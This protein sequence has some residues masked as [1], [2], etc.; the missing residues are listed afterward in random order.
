M[1]SFRRLG[2]QPARLALVADEV[3]EFHASRLLLLFNVCGTSDRIEG[4]TKLAKLDFFVRYPAFFDRIAKPSADAEASL[5]DTPSVESPMVRHHYGPWDRR[6]YHVLAYLE[7]RG[8]IRVSKDGRAYI[9][10]LTD[11][12]R[13]I[14]TSLRKSDEFSD[15][16]VQM[17]RVKKA[18]GRFSGSRLKQM[19]YDEFGREVAD[20]PMGDLIE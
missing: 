12:G 3:V 11:K 16:V 2:S 10:A 13:E 18:V 20:K 9:F 15:L 7:A 14:A 5:D 19:I 17:Q 6:Y 8:L 1:R 4:L